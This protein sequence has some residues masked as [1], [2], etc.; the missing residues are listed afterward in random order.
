MKEK[1]KMQWWVPMSYHVAQAKRD[2]RIIF[3]PIAIAR[4]VLAIVMI[5]IAAAYLLPRRIPDFEFDWFS[6]FFKCMG[7]L[8]VILGMGCALAFIPPMLTV[9]T[10]GITVSQG[11]HARLYRYADLAELRIGESGAPH[12]MLIFR[13]RSQSEPK[14]Y[15]VSQKIVI[16]DLN[17]LIDKNRVT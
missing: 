14:Q 11:Q 5:F 12:P 3:S 6:A 1:S 16:D 17:A 13:L 15:P 7:F 10:K 4:I 9:T 2:L 8:L